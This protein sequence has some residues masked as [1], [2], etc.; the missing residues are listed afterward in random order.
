MAPL[1]TFKN[2]RSTSMSTTP[3]VVRTEATRNESETV[4]KV[5]RDGEVIHEI[6]E[7]SNKV[8][9]V[10]KEMKTSYDHMKKIWLLNVVVDKHVDVSIGGKIVP[11]RTQENITIPL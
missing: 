2:I 3:P 1:N 11:M 7:P 4:Y 9:F 5:V 8:D 6:K 10:T